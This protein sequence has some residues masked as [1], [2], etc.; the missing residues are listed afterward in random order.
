MFEIDEFNPLLYVDYKS[1]GVC[2]SKTCFVNWKI[3]KAHMNGSQKQSNFC[4]RYYDGLTGA[5]RASS[6]P[7]LVFTDAQIVIDSI[8]SNTLPQVKNSSFYAKIRCTEG[9]QYRTHLSQ[10]GIWDN[11]KLSFPVDRS[12]E[13]QFYL[14]ERCW[15]GDKIIGE[16]NIPLA[17]L[18]HR[19][20][21]D[22]AFILRPPGGNGNGQFNC[23]ILISCHL[24]PARHE[25][26]EE[27][28][29]NLRMSRNAKN[30]D[31]R[32]GNSLGLPLSGSV[33][34][35]SSN[36]STS[37]CSSDRPSTSSS[38]SLSSSSHNTLPSGWEIRVD[39]HGRLIYL[40][41]V[42]KRTTWQPPTV[43]EKDPMTSSDISQRYA[44]ARRT[45]IKGRNQNT[46]PETPKKAKDSKKDR[47]HSSSSHPQPV[48]FLLRHNFVNT[49]HNNPEALRVYNESAYL[50]HIIHRIRRD[51]SKFDKFEQNR[52]LVE[53][54]N[55]FADKTQPLPEG[56]QIARQGD[57]QQRL[58]IDHSSRRITLIDPRLPDEIKRRTRSAPPNRRQFRREDMNGNTIVDILQRTEELKKLVRKRFPEA[59][60]K[61]CKKL[62][63]ISRMGE[64][65][66]LHFANDVDLITAIS[67]LESENL[68]S[69]DRN[70][71][72]EKLS[73]FYTSLQRAGY[74]QGPGKIRF[75]LRR[76]HLMQDAFDKIL[77][78]DP[79]T[80]KKYH[81]TV[82]FDDEDGLDYGGP[83]RELFFLLSRELFNPYYGL[84]EY[85]A[86]DT[87]TVQI[88]PMSKFVDN[89]LRWMELCGRVLALALIHR[90]MLDTFFTRAFYKLLIGLPYKIN[91]LQCMD[92]QFHNSLLWIRENK[93]TPDLDLT[94]STTEEI[95]GEII[96]KELLPGGKDV[97]V[98]DSNKEEFINLMLR[99][100]V[101]RNVEEQGKALLRGIYSIVDR[102][103][104]RIFDAEQLELVLSGTVEID[105]E[106]WR[107]NTEYKGGFYDGHVVVT[108]FWNTVYSMNNADRLKLLQFV[109]GTSSIP[110][111]GFKALRGSNGPRKFTIEK[112]GHEES[113][114]RAHTC[115]NRLDLPAYPTEKI[116]IDK[117]R[118]AI[119][120]SSSYAI[121]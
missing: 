8:T 105:I 19:T 46:D 25:S 100:R 76:D 12:R 92:S 47:D 44:C 6:P 112:W 104:L 43:L 118:I 107:E 95:A 28:M 88:S 63:I 72:E 13:L 9:C 16:A 106:D 85:S 58:F 49:L 40:D 78:V 24:I 41:H 29:S 61:I 98:T 68:E 10:H 33:S 45:V 109:T 86:N 18:V 93:I 38:H 15:K 53:F 51:P 110:F 96:E 73:Y 103:Y 42:N 20:N 62:A 74:A 59:A 14:K 1:Y 32:N 102:D 56:W 82:T 7:L 94:F 69:R 91:D 83:S 120:E 111:E 26:L 67:A 79:I 64:P 21:K 34:S 84:F 36:M 101:E 77:A 81:M 108:W 57:Q 54:I 97:L 17:E 55:L 23:Q 99:W 65:A 117:L 75:R 31:V 60:P 2:G 50:K 113:L 115:F 121:E 3:T 35:G 39:R 71:F 4:F 116:L 80:L 114:P 66:L 11:L 30:E 70:E 89:Y 87:Y 5:L 37:T 48:R 22:L 90:C 119:N 52:E 27:T